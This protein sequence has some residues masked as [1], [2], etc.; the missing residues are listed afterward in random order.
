VRNG[1]PVAAAKRRVGYLSLVGR[2]GKT[3]TTR[4]TFIDESGAKSTA[5]KKSR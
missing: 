2:K 3:R 5:T 1:V 4:V